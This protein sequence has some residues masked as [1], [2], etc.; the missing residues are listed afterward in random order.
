MRE[1]AIEKALKD[2]VKKHGGKAYKFV[3]PGMSGVPDRIVLLPGG[4][5][6]FVE[7]KAPGKKLEPLQAKR[8]KELEQFGFKVFKIDSFAGVDEFLKEVLQDGV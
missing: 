8:K 4:R 3:S 2:G 5:L 7:T 6:F 1:S